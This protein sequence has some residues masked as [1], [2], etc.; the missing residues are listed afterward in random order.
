MR[1]E[2]HVVSRLHHRGRSIRVAAGSPRFGFLSRKNV[3]CHEA[4]SLQIFAMAR[5]LLGEKF[6]FN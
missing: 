3:F 1:A 6:N 5:A 4:F 2:L